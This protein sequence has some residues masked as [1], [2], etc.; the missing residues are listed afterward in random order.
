M[1]LSV[2]WLRDSMIMCRLH[3]GKI[4][5]AA[6]GKAQ[7]DVVKDQ[8]HAKDKFSRFHPTSSRLLES[9]ASGRSSGVMKR[10]ADARRSVAS[11]KDLVN[12]KILGLGLY[13]SSLHS[14]SSMIAVCSF[15]QRRAILCSRCLLRNSYTILFSSHFSCLQKGCSIGTAALSKVLMLCFNS[16]LLSLIILL[17]RRL[18]RLFIFDGSS[19]G[20]RGILYWLWIRYLSIC[21]SRRIFGQIWRPLL[22]SWLCNSIGSSRSLER[23]HQRRLVIATIWSHLELHPL[24]KPS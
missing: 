11:A 6:P 12:C 21:F 24:S 1:V 17:A 9:R 20:T 13:F 19:H 10:I 18:L 8:V 23:I 16:L 7:I 5:E 22:G 2:R 14:R 3:L 4:R 15:R